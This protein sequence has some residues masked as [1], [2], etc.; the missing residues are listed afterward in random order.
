MLLKYIKHLPYLLIIIFLNGCFHEESIEDKQKTNPTPDTTIIPGKGANF[1]V[2]VLHKAENCDDFKTYLSQNLIEQYLENESNGWGF[3]PFCVTGGFAGV[4]DDG[5][6]T[7][8]PPAAGAAGGEAS[9]SSAVTNPGNVTGTNNQESGVD[10]LDK[11]KTDSK[12]NIYLTENKKLYIFDAFPPQNMNILS[13]KDIANDAYGLFLDEDNARLIILTHHSEKQ[14]YSNIPMDYYGNYFK[15]YINLLF[16]DI[17]DLSSPITTKEIKLEGSFQSAR[18]IE[19]RLHL[20]LNHW[21]HNVDESFTTKS[22]MDDLERYRLA[23]K[24]DFDS[25]QEDISRLKA[26][27]SEKIINGVN[28]IELDSVLPTKQLDATASSSL[29]QCDNIYHP[30]VSL[31]KAELLSVVSVNS[32]G[33]AFNTVGAL[34]SGAYVYASQN[35]MYVAQ[36]S[37]NWWWN[38]QNETTVIHQFD[39]GI[40]KTNYVAS[41]QVPGFVKGQFSF[42]EYNSYLRV[43]TTENFQEDNATRAERYNHLYVLE[44]NNDVLNTIGSVEK[45]APGDR[46]FSSRFMGDRGFVV[47][48]RNIDPLFAFDLSD[49]SNP[50]IKG[51]LEIP[52]FSTY[53]HPI[54]DNHLLTIGKA[55]NNQGASSETQLQIFNVSDLNN[56]VRLFAHVPQML[57]DNTGW[58]YSIAESDHHAFTYSPDDNILSIPLSFYNWQN[59][60][61]FAGIVTFN[62]DLING[63]TENGSVDHSDLVPKQDCSK[64]NGN[65]EIIYDRSCM[66]GFYRYNSLPNRSVIMGTEDGTSSYLFSISRLGI[67]ANYLTEMSNVIS[68]ISI[69]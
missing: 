51:E 10:E 44:R 61:S 65:S 33:E 21:L 63:I 15:S 53:M 3:C 5:V 62:I 39:I 34:A 50:E 2:D 8:M 9:D 31:K 14:D 35:S 56:P 47:T 46:I 57:Q 54:D 26:E 29:L 13:V 66:E 45:F 69:N 18:F 20:V 22:F 42:S 24:L 38:Q 43:A 23:K 67:K 58:G 19:N 40:D 52:G 64:D 27:L 68:A 7:S 37:G 11:V 1:K 55:G 41:G 12:G 16:I 59:S 32:D 48:F 49:P 25:I 4:V 60:E 28:A 6:N 17:S 36:T 30:E